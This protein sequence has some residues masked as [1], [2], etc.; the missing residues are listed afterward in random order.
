MKQRITGTLEV[1]VLPTIALAVV[2]GVAPGRIELAVRIYGL[3][4]CAVVL[5][6]ALAALRDA[7]PPSPPLQKPP[8]VSRARRQPPPALARIEHETALGVAGSFDLHFRLVPR[9][10]TLASGLLLARRQVSFEASPEDARRRLGDETWGLVRPDRQVPEDRLAR[11][12][13][14]AAL[15]RVVESLERI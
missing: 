8:V 10:R 2:A 3:I 14:P 13:D 12:I 15:R 7:Y 11:G 1:L 6:V 4:V 5:Y 9:L